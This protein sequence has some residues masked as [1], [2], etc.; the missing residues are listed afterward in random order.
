LT[1]E[2]LSGIDEVAPSPQLVVMRIFVKTGF[3]KGS[4]LAP[5]PRAGSEGLASTS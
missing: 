4:A 2:T 5:K 3:V 1:G